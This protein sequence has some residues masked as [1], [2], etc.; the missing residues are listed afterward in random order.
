M[1]NPDASHPTS[2]R[3][4]RRHV[5]ALGGLTA[6]A[7]VGDAA[8]RPQRAAAS[9]PF[10]DHP[11]S[12]GVASGDPL[13]D[14][15]VLWTRLAPDP[16]AEDGNGGMPAETFGVRYEVAEDEKFARIVRRGAVE[17]TPELG[18][19]VHVEL[20][21][22]K[23]A[24]EYFYRF[25]FGPTI[26]PVGRTKTAPA[27]D[28]SV[29]RLRLAVTSC[30]NYS[31][32]YFPSYRDIVASDLDLVVFLGDYIYEGPGPSTIG[33]SHVPAKTITTLADYRIRHAQYKADPLLQA[34]HSTLPFL[35]VPDDHE[36]TNNYAGDTGGGQSGEEF[37]ARRAAAYQAYY[38]N[39]PLR[40]SSLPVGPDIRLYRRV[41]FGDLALF[42]MLDTR[43]YRSVQAKW[44]AATAVNGYSPGEL[45]PNRTILGDAQ[46]QWLQEGLATSTARWN[47]LG[48]QTKFAPYD[49]R[50]GP[51]LD[52][53][54]T[55][56]WG[57]GY[58]ADRDQL[59]QYIAAHR[60]SN[61]VI[62]TGDAH[63]NWVFNLKA[64]F[65]DPNSETVATEYL[66]TSIS[67]GGDGNP[68]S[69]VYG[70]TTDNP[71]MMLQNGQR[72]Y[73]RVEVTPE[74]WRAEFRVSDSVSVPDAPLY[75]LAT[76]VTNNGTP[77]ARRL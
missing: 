73:I 17:A 22:L 77:G 70:P 9:P 18:H 14:G 49:R 29:E 50:V 20:S 15:V 74:Q 6:A 2:G 36:V 19:S 16:L 11:F 51:G 27:F 64:D 57:E 53:S 52:Y 45:D 12:L 26:S 58:V 54:G 10:F 41:R 24:R 47:I 59:L 61:P 68:N 76:F 60:P 40:R 21:G 67:S 8:T 69:T 28:A 71:H 23:P 55:D 25:R 44:S 13:P 75:T 37:L 56:N 7:I 33:R 5:L 42:H 31:N 63:K 48:N 4:N 66:G 30:Q 62:I 43:Q 32:G 38:E 39:M 34:A 35:V 46:E 72:G 1:S 3:L 65:N